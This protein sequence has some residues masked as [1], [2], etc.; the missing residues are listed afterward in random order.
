MAILVS[1][2]R[3]V[4]NEELDFP[5]DVNSAN[6]FS[7]NKLADQLKQTHDIEV[8]GCDHNSRWLQASQPASQPA[9]QMDGQTDRQ[10][11]IRTLMNSSAIGEN[12][13]RCNAKT[14]LQNYPVL[15][16]QELVM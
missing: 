3:R 15:P 8:R 10:T 14:M 12:A 7:V 11:E 5:S 16:L 1:L 13:S 6:L 4:R 9:G 2:C